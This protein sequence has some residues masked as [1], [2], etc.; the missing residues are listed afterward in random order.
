VA[1]KFRKCEKRGSEKA[2]SSQGMKDI[3]IRRQKME[4]DE[5]AGQF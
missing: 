2:I 5:A 3:F 4:S 1:L